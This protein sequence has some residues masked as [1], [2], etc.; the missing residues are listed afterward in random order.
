MR[1]KLNTN[2]RVNMYHN[3]KRLNT[4]NEINPFT[5][6]ST[7]LNFISNVKTAEIDLTIYNHGFATT[8]GDGTGFYF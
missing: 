8:F 5:L 4:N 1:H 3:Y 2:I 7:G 6:T